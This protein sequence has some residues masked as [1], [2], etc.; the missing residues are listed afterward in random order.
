MFCSQS[1]I[2]RTEGVGPYH[3]AC[4]ARSPSRAKPIVSPAP[5][6][7]QQPRPVQLPVRVAQSVGLPPQALQDLAYYR[8]VLFPGPELY[9]GHLHLSRLLITCIT[10]PPDSASH[11][12]PYQV[13]IPT[14]TTA[15]QYV[16]NQPDFSDLAVSA[17][18]SLGCRTGFLLIS[19]RLA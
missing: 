13:L 3:A 15:W 14:Y 5:T 8:T 18:R 4:L 7:R 10:C 11:S 2:F 9:G 12:T 19:I 6:R 16:S 17:S 1:P